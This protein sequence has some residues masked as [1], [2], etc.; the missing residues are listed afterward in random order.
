MA[1]L[2]KKRLIRIKFWPLHVL[3]MSI[4]AFAIVDARAQKLIV[5]PVSPPPQ[6]NGYSLVFSDDFDLLDLGPDGSGSHAWYEGVWFNHKHAP[7]SNIHADSSV[8]YLDWTRGQDAPDTSVTTL[9]RDK[10]TAKTWRYAYF[11][12]RFKWTP[13]TGAWPAF[14]LIP[15]QDAM[16]QAVYGGTK[17]S[18]EIDVFEGQGNHPGIFY[19][20]IHDWVNLRDSAS[21]NNAF[22]LPANVDLSEFHTYGL[23][24]V[25]GKVTWYFDNLA[26]HSEPTPAIFD[27]QDFF[28]ILGMQEG[29]DWKLGELTGVK[30]SKLTL[31]VDWVRVWQ[32]R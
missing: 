19:G 15:V 11:E 28:L 22:P 6:A 30:A 29:V 18:G 1:T 14:W 32:K 2:S 8:L 20:T 5:S 9:S 16:G 26:L 7:L 21:R 25:P 24:W 17:E 10:K 3:L 12:A 27:K 13:S 23:L 4:V 31:G